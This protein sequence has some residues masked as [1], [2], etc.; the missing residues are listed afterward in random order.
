MK[1]FFLIFIFLFLFDTVFSLYDNYAEKIEIKI[2]K[3]INEIRKQNSLSSLK[4]NK[5][6]NMIAKDHSIDMV[7]KNYTDHI[8]PYGLNPNDRAKNAGFNII[9]RKNNVIYEGVGENIFQY[10]AFSELNGIKISYLEK[11][12]IVVKNAVDS[13]MKSEGHRK[14]ILNPDYTITGIGVAVSKDKK[15]KITQLFF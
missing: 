11:V 7:K 9:K 14:N 15:I 6:L 10:Q 1:K 5:K 3:L 13:W 2:F 8:S 4:I 12:D